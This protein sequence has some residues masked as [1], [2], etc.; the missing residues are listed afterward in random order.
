M[1]SWH[2]LDSLE[3]G[4]YQ[5]NA[6]AFLSNFAEHIYAFITTVYPSSGGWFQKQSQ[7]ISYCFSEDDIE[8]YVLQWPIHSPDLNP[9]D[10]LMDVLEQEM[11]M[12]VQP[13]KLYQL[14]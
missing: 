5:L 12:D 2:T 3:P 13:T 4:D 9:V 7:M 11:D 1:F 8:F 6:I 14:C 10:H